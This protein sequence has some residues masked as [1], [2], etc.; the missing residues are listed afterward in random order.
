MKI[1]FVVHSLDKKNMGGVNRVVI[2]LA[3][4]LVEKNFEI[5]IYS[6]GQINNLCYEISSD[7]RI[8]SL[9]MSKHST[10]QYSGLQKIKWVKKSY[11]LLKVII[12]DKYDEIWLTS[13]PPLN[14]LFSILK[15][16]YPTLRVIGCDHTSTIYSKG[17]FVDKFKNLLLKKLN[18]IVALTE[19]DRKNYLNK[20]LNTIFIPNF[21]DLL[22]IKLNKNNRKF[23]IFVGRLS[24]EKQPIDAIKIYA[25]SRLWEQDIKFRIFGY[26]ELEPKVIKFIHENKIEKHVELIT[27]ESNLENIYQNAYAL[28]MTSKVEGFGMVLL[29]A[30]SRN[31][32]C[33]AYN[34]PYGPE[35]IIINGING[36]LVDFGDIESSSKLLKNISLDKFYNSDI[37]ATLNLFSKEKI[38]QQWLEV[39]NNV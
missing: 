7:I 31:I 3:E 37:Q 21:I 28:L 6:L 35:S 9:G 2:D 22:S 15:Y 29:E 25:L 32:P 18:Y 11:Q 38:I 27:N 17:F 30:I 24:E 20:G 33:I 26:G 13:S 23:V 16:S 19:Q 39:L 12:N 34:V 8:I 36:Y 1:N 5:T 14:L 10:N 4:A